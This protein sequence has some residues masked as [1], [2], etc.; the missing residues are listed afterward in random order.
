[1]NFS[2]SGRRALVLGGSSDLALALAVPLIEAGLHPILTYRSDAGKERIDVHLALFASG[3]ETAYCDFARTDSI[4]TLFKTVGKKL[5]YVIDFAQG[6]LEAYIASANQDDVARYISENITARSRILK[7]A[8]RLMLSGRKGR[9][10][11]VSSTAALRPNPGQGFY[12]A[13]KLAAEALYRNLGLELG[14][15]GITAVT[16][17]PGYISAGRGRSFIQDNENE[18]LKRIPT[19]KALSASEVASAIM[20]LL[21]DGA[22]GFNATEIVMDGGLSAGKQL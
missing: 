6:D 12:A 1:M 16:L 11:F 15:R 7:E 3:Y 22:A 20:F 2:F 18:V 19:G 13:A 14:K 10:V 8:G 4:D 5:D 9:L 17:R 21:S